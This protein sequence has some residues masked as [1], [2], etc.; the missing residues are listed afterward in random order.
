M[1]FAL[2]AGCE[3][4]RFAAIVV[5]AVVLAGFRRFFEGNVVLR[6]EVNEFRRWMRDYAVGVLTSFFIDLFLRFTSRSI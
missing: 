2:G 1:G 4:G 5:A 3:E 6:D